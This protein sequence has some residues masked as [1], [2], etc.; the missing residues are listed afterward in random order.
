MKLTPHPKAGQAISRLEPAF[1]AA[2]PTRP[3]S[4][5]EMVV[6]KRADDLHVSLGIALIGLDVL[7]AR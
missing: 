7:D 4:R 1:S 2:R 6:E 5:P 3:P